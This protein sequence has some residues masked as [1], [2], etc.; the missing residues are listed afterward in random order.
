MHIHTEQGLEDREDGTSQ[1]PDVVGEV[2]CEGVD[3]TLPRMV[4]THVEYL[5]N[6]VLEMAV[7]EILP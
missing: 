3:H 2:Y 4:S 5:N 6:G 7:F 1:F